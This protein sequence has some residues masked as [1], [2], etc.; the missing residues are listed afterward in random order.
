VKPEL[1]KAIAHTINILTVITVTSLFASR[2]GAG[3]ARI[4]PVL[5]FGIGLIVWA[6]HWATAATVEVSLVVPDDEDDHDDDDDALGGS[7]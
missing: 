4:I 2:P 3:G 5:V 7:T 6:Y 1:R